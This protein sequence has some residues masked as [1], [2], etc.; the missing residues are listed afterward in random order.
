MPQWHGDLNKKKPSG[1]RKRMMRGK[2]A[3][4]MGSPPA[5]TIIGE[6]VA[7]ARRGR[8]GSFKTVLLAADI[9][10]VTDP[11]TG[12]SQKTTI[13]RVLKNAANVDYERRGV[14]TKGSVIETPLGQARVVSR[15][16]QHGVV[17][18]I[19]IEKAK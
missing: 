16:G 15:P 3:H 10:N 14:I 17:N 12:T 19:L 11:A 8:G 1:G 18:A 7:R 9:A 2:R 13:E 5:A 6:T 4:E